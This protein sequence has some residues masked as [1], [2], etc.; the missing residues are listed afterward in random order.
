MKELGPEARGIVEA[1]RDADRPTRGDR[2]RVRQ[3]L[4]RTL[5]AGAFG[6]ASTAAPAAAGHAAAAAAAK[7]TS[8]AALTAKVLAAIAVVGITGA[9][10]ALIGRGA[11]GPGALP[12][13]PVAVDSPEPIPVEAKDRVLQGPTGAP[14]VAASPE[15]PQP[16]GAS[17]PAVDPRGTAAPRAHVGSAR[18]SA[19]EPG[20]SAE[21][22]ASP[23]STLEA[24]TRLLREA[25]DALQAGQPGRA[26][27]LLDEQSQAYAGGQL[28]EERAAARVLALCKAGRPEEA[29]AAA[30][31]FLQEHPHSPLADRVRSA[32]SALPAPAAAP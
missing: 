7:G 28:V 6:A 12:A 32:C 10:I 29:Q 18:A 3:A 16:A 19:G 22:A 17:R 2:A 5:A 27:D 23:P 1:G 4:S 30:A 21:P 20:A 8:A 24:E 31:R 14:A 9:G 25:H 13:A 26:L 15:P 11:D